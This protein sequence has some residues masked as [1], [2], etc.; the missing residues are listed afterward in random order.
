MS[1]FALAATSRSPLTCTGTLERAHA[2]LEHGLDRVVA[3]CEAQAEHLLD[4]L[5]DHLLLL[6]ARERERV[7]AAADHAA[8][9]VAHE[10]R[11]VG[12]RVVVVEQLEQEGEA[13]LRAALGLAR[14][15]DVAVELAACGDRSWGR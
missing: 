2:P 15:A 1:A 6:E 7:L 10:E 14:E 4:A 8:L 3:V 11:G 9:A 12:R 13:A 5:A